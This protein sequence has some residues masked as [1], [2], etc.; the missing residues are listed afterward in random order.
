MRQLSIPMLLMLLALALPSGK[1][2]AQMGYGNNKLL[3]YAT[4]EDGD[5]IPIFHLN[6]VN[7]ITKWTLLT[8][9]EIKK[10]HY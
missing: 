1:L 8:D 6:T 3:A 7:I 10:N 9:K 2:Q 5:T 4:I